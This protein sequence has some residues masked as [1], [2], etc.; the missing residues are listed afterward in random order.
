MLCQCKVNVFSLNAA[1]T[2]CCFTFYFTATLRRLVTRNQKAHALTVC[3]NTT[4]GTRMCQT[5]HQ[6]MSLIVNARQS[7]FTHS[8]EQEVRLAKIRRDWALVKQKRKPSK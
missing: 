3:P 6:A 8:D 7:I 4:S 2:N 5:H 1:H